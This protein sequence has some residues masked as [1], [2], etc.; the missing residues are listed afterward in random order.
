MFYI[1]IIY[2]TVHEPSRNFFLFCFLI[3]KSPPL[4]ETT[5]GLKHFSFDCTF[6]SLLIPAHL[7]RYYYY[8]YHVYKQLGT[9]P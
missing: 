1:I 6:S 7:P 9:Q 8:F 4:I 2:T 5:A 3:K